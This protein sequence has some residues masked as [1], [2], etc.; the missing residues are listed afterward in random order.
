M[1]IDTRSPLGGKGPILEKDTLFDGKPTFP[2]SKPKLQNTGVG[3]G[4]ILPGEDLI[5]SSGN[6]KNPF[7]S[8]LIDN[9]GGPKPKNDKS[10][11]ELILD[12]TPQEQNRYPKPFVGP[13]APERPV[14]SGPFGAPDTSSSGGGGSFG[15]IDPNGDYQYDDSEVYPKPTTKN[16]K[17]DYTAPLLG[18]RKII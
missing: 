14:D 4:Q 6:V 18:E 9:L 17:P 13:P 2:P 5:D 7:T 12:F 10:G 3:S 1:P 8:P 11:M 15:N 16:T